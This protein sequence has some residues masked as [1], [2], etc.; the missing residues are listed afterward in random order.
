MGQW[1]FYDNEGD[2]V[3]DLVIDLESFC[4]PSKFSN[5]TNVKL[6][7]DWMSTH[8]MI[9][10]KY[11]KKMDKKFNFEDFYF[12]GLAFHMASGWGEKDNKSIDKLP[13]NFPKWLK[14]K[15]LKASK[16]LLYEVT[17]GNKNQWKDINRRKKAL[18]HQINLFS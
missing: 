15:A 13:L 3:Q 5:L 8:L 4:L 9:V 12:S 10:Q 14:M 2:S 18:E 1:G 6:K 7:N 16:T 11:F 17:H